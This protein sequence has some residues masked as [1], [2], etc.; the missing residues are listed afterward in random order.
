MFNNSN[1]FIWFHYVS[2]HDCVAFLI[3]NLYSR[4]RPP[5][6]PRPADSSQLSHTTYSH[7]TQLTHIPLTHNLLT[8]NLPTYHL[9][10]HTHNLPTYH[11]PTHTHT[12]Y[13][14]TTYPGNI[15]AT[16]TVTS[17]RRHGT[18]RH[19]PSLCV[20]GVALGHIDRH[21]ALQAWRLWRRCC[22]GRLRGRRGTWSHRPS[23]CLAG[24]VLGDVD[25]HFA[26]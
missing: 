1:G 18:W 3:F 2:A 16:S 4:P 15:Q 24:V 9:P 10:T 25:R 5:H 26:W 14:H 23:L 22:R 19:R 21:F 8:H 7:T 11:L 6:P 13:P 12:T 20:A 17:R